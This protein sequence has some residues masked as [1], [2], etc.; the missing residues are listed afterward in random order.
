MTAKQIQARL[1]AL[2]SPEGAAQALRFFKT[3]PGEYGEGDRFRGIKVPLVRGVAKEF[4]DLAFAEAKLLLASPFHEDRLAALA[5][6]CRQF[7]AGDEA[8]R[9]RIYRLYLG[10]ARWVNNWD[11]VD[12]SAPQILGGFLHKK[13]KAPLYKLAQSANLWERRMAIIATLWYI[14]EKDCKDALKLAEK[15]LDA[16]EDLL[17]KAVGWMLREVG[18]RDR[19]AEEVFLARHYRTMPRTTLRYA[20]EH[21]PETRRKAY[22]KGEI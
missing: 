5:I 3:G 14:R 8:V 13:D 7:Q 21:F 15:L 18:K 1:E 9:E 17:H 4:P 19:K 10:G 12:V 22:L 20:I 11:L 2:G 6:L 16:P